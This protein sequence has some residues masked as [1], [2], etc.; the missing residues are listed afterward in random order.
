MRFALH[1][2]KVALVLALLCWWA[3]PAQASFYVTV[4][5]GGSSTTVSDNDTRDTDSSTGSIE[6]T[7]NVGFY[8]VIVTASTTSPG[9]NGQG[10]VTQTSLTVRK[11]QA[12]TDSVTI[13][14][15]S[16]G[17]T[18]ANQGSQVQL[19]NAVSSSLML[20]DGNTPTATAT[21]SLNSSTTDA[22]VLSGEIDGTQE[23]ASS[24]LGVTVSSN[25]FSLS[26]K[27]VITD[28]N[29]YNDNGNNATDANIGVTT[30]ATALPC[31]PS[32][33]LLAGGLPV[34]GL[35]W[36]RRRRA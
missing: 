7:V 6:A 20:G 23:S 5:V 21:S 16:D 12:T 24:S 11:T 8:R 2:A 10:I 25:P 29:V 1:S 13:E 15:F 34:G 36:L 22:A 27:V 26:N 18:F 3:S 35:F 9:A 14:V 32:L 4:T 30:T 31:P 19:N 28:L 33:A 17:F